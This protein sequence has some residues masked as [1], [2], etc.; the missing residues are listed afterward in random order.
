MKRPCRLEVDERSSKQEKKREECT[1]GGKKGKND[2]EDRAVL[3][4]RGDR[5]RETGFCG[6]HHPKFITPFASN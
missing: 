5:V 4:A 3:K 6:P 2:N 1:K